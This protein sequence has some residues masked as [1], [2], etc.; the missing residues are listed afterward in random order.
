VTVLVSAAANRHP[1]AVSNTNRSSGASAGPPNFG[2]PEH[3]ALT[4]EGRIERAAGVAGRATG[5]RDRRER[6][7]RRSNWAAG[8]LLIAG[9]FGL[10]IV[11]MV[12]LY[13]LG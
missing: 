9:V 11:L 6:P 10:L 13:T 12:V 7:L 4:I 5:V 8:L 1:E 3:S 2:L